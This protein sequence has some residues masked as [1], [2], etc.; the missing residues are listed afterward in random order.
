MKKEEPLIMRLH[1]QIHMY[2]L[3]RL[4]GYEGVPEAE[5][6]ETIKPL[7]A[8]HTLA[9]MRPA[10]HELTQTDEKTRL[11][12]LRPEVRRIAFQILGPPPE[13]EDYESYWAS[14]GVLPPNKRKREEPPKPA[15]EKSK[16]RTRKKTAK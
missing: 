11:V 13:R 7:V 1:F 12:T 8:A 15:E 9:K 5:L 10:A 2:E 16:K 4:I 3:V 14:Q 6:C